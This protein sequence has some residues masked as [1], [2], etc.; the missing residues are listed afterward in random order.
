M[1]YLLDTDI[2]SNLMRREPSLTLIRK[3]ALVP[4]GDQCTSAITLGEL[5]YGAHRVPDRAID[6]LRRIDGLIPVHLPVLPF[7]ESAARGYG[8]VRA[9][10]EH[11]GTLVGEAD[12]RIAGIALAHGLTVVTANVRHFQRIP[13]LEVEDWLA[14]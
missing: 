9:R 8:Y 5:V 7:D 13:G 2:I 11:A 1:R 3:V 4:P 14:A 10:L 12:M 6:L